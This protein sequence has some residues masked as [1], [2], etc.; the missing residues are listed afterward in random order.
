[1][2]MITTTENSVNILVSTICRNMSVAD[3]NVE[4]GLLLLILIHQAGAGRNHH[5]GEHHLLMAISLAMV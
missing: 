1:M 4:A 3:V 5:V 2:P